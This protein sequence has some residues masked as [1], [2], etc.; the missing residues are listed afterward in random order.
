MIRAQHSLRDGPSR[1]AVP[2]LGGGA[3]SAAGG[4]LHKYRLGADGRP[5]THHP[6][7]VPPSAVHMSLG[8]FSFDAPA[9]VDGAAL[10]A[11]FDAREGCRVEGWL[12]A[13]RVA[14]TISF[15]PHLEDYLATRAARSALAGQ[16]ADQLR[17]AGAEGRGAA[18]LPHVLRIDPDFSKMNVM[19]VFHELSFESGREGGC[20]GCDGGGN[21]H[22]HHR[23][24]GHHHRSRPKKSARAR[25]VARARSG[26]LGK[27]VQEAF[28]RDP[29]SGLIRGSPRSTGSWKYF[30][31]VVPTTLAADV[32]GRRAANEADAKIKNAEKRA[33]KSYNDDDDDYDDDGSYF[34]PASSTSHP[35]GFELHAVHAYQY[36]LTEK[37][38]PLDARRPSMPT[39][40]LSYDMSPL[41]LRLAR[42]GAPPLHAAVRLVAVAGGIRALASFAG[43]VVHA[44]AGR[45]RHNNNGGGAKE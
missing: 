12:A 18:F 45:R 42:P 37:F 22:H 33:A 14:G 35:A 25:A 2:S 1:T 27:D 17:R 39:V 29:L 32:V 20:S 34:A 16:L 28:P 6:E 41:S 21:H 8:G 11:A 4:E 13:Q 30:A 43:A 7:F 36:S 38:S 15:R 31:K 9:A 40:T 24:H 3:A 44:L 19:H 23:H 5:L 10:D 26:A